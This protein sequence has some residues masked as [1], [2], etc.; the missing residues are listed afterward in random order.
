MGSEEKAQREWFLKWTSLTAGEF[1][2]LTGPSA[3]RVLL[4]P[5][6][7]YLASAAILH[8][9]RGRSPQP[10]REASAGPGQNPWRPGPKGPAAPSTF[11][12]KP[13]QPSGIP[14]STAP[15]TGIYRHLNHLRFL[16]RSFAGAQDDVGGRDSPI[17]IPTSIPITTPVP[18]P[19]APTGRPIP[20][21]AQVKIMSPKSSSG[22]LQFPSAGPSASFCRLFNPQAMPILP[23]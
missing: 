9:S 4:A 5:L 3:S 14:A 1:V 7:P 2:S 13:R 11:A 22:V 17:P 6:A 20:I 10:V 12:A 18:I 19:T 16:P 8:N 23:S 15:S 21:S